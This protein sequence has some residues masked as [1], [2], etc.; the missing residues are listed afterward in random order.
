MRTNSFR[1]F[2]FGK[3]R[4]AVFAKSLCF[5]FSD[6][7]VCLVDE[8]VRRSGSWRGSIHLKGEALCQ[9]AVT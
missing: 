5:G 6:H 1:D 8:A 7:E 2:V 3:R 4:K 9:D